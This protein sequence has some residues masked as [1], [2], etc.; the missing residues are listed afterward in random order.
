RWS[1]PAWQ[2]RGRAHPAVA[3]LDVGA[4]VTAEGSRG[5][6]AGV[7]GVRDY[8]G[9]DRSVVSGCASRDFEADRSWAHRAAHDRP[10]PRRGV[11]A[12]S[13][14]APRGPARVAPFASVPGGPAARATH[15]APA[16][17]LR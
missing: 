1:R 14:D 5:H 12:P 6:P 17:A 10:D 4:A 11:R 15:R 16:D 7:R 2:V 8:V 3:R 9:L 13:R